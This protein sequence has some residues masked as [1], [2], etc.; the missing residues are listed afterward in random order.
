[1]F[2]F[3]TNVKYIAGTEYSASDVHFFL[4]VPNGFSEELATLNGTKAY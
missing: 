4:P 3:S 1:M 2:K